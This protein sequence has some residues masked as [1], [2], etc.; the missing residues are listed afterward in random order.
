MVG[1][2]T[3][4]RETGFVTSA[5]L[6][7]WNSLNSDRVHKTLLILHS[8]LNISIEDVNWGVVDINILI[9]VCVLH[10]ACVCLLRGGCLGCFGCLLWCWLL[11]A[12]SIIN[13][14]VG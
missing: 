5:N 14:L 12:L 1:I 13:E 3:W 10:E 7:K 8:A 11:N 6:I 9:N 2:N 4:C